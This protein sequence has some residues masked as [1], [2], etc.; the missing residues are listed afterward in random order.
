MLLR[1]SP[2]TLVHSDQR[3]TCDGVQ[4]RYVAK[5]YFLDATQGT[6]VNSILNTFEA[7]PNADFW[8]LS[9]IY[10]RLPHECKKFVD[11][12]S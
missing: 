8:A 6:D 4:Q 12:I 1:Q 5:E 3:N 2:Q 7:C 9:Q 10:Q 11:N